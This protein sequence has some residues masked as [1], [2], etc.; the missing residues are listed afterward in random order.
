[1]RINVI[2]VEL[3]TPRQLNLNKNIA[4]ILFWYIKLGLIDW[5]NLRMF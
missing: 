4:K 5:Q 1:M 3:N 2:I